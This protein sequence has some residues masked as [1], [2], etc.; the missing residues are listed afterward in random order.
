[1]ELNHD[2]KIGDEVYHVSNPQMIMAIE[3]IEND[4]IECSFWDK[5]SNKHVFQ[6]FNYTSL[7]KKDNGP[8]ITIVNSLP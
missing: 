2:F 3:N 1:M 8:K 7:R 6:F 4:K 5:V